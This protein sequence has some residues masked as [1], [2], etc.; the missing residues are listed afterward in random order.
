VPVATAAQLRNQ[1]L[2][3]PALAGP[4][5]GR[6]SCRLSA[7]LLWGRLCKPQNLI[8]VPAVK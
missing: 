4:T 1:H 5:P 3:H 2:L 6:L 8:Q 7:R